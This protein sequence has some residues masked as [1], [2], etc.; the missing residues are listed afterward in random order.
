MTGEGVFAVFLERRAR[1]VPEV[2]QRRP[3]GVRDIHGM[4]ITLAISS[5]VRAECMWLSRSADNTTSAR[6]VTNGPSLR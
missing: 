4:R 3:V 5:G 2:E 6:L 1:A